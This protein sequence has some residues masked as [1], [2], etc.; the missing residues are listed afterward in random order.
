MDVDM[1]SKPPR[2]HEFFVQFS[3]SN[4]PSKMDPG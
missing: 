2:E 3:K 1:D 4:F